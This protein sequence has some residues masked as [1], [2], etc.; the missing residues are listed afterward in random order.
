MDI[1][2]PAQVNAVSMKVPAFIESNVLVWFA[3]IEAH[4]VISGITSS[5]KKFSHALAALPTDILGRMQSSIL[6]SFD[7][8][9]LKE[10]VMHTLEK[11]KPE[12]L[13]KLMT[14]SAISGRPS[15]YL[16]E[17]VSLAS[18]IGV[19]DDIIR[20]KFIQALP[21]S[22][23]SVIASQTDLDIDRLGKMAD[24][25]LA[26]FNTQAPIQ[27]ICQVAHSPRREKEQQQKEALHK[28]LD[29]VR[30]SVRPFHRD[31]LPKICRA[32][33]YYADKARFCK[34]WCKWPNKKRALD[35][36]PSSRPASPTPSH[37]EN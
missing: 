21:V 23:K 16:N 6:V 36:Q 35:I 18:R 34:S 11:S 13:D 1:E 10:A 19:G 37:S 20:H 9:R 17:L 15:V 5:T 3:I 26:Y 32:H 14:S 22:I 27:P 30:S 8:E 4:F 24:D 29:S 7:Y 12:L 25:V 31:Q 28:R 2:E 33:L